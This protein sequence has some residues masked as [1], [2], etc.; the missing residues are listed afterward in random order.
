M[1]RFRYP[2]IAALFEGSHVSSIC[3]SGKNNMKISVSAEHGWNGGDRRQCKCLEKKLSQANLGLHNSHTKWP[4]TE[5]GTQKPEACIDVH[6]I[7]EFPP[8]IRT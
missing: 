7:S 4:W 1:A 6:R 8:I 2:K 5:N 3:P